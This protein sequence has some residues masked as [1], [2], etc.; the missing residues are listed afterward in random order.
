VAN[1][2]LKDFE[3]K[4]CVVKYETLKT[5]INVLNCKVMF[6]GQD[7]VIINI[8]RKEISIP[9]N[10]IHQIQCFEGGEPLILKK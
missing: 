2:R 5:A 8:G 6:V 7:S 4:Q 10:N 3:G 1:L 9:K